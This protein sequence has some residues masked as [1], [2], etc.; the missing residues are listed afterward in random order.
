MHPI[1]VLLTPLGRAF[2]NR[3]SDESASLSLAPEL[4]TDTRLHLA[5][6]SFDDGGVIPAAHC[7]WLIGAN[8]SPALTWRALPAGT[9]ELLL[10]FEDLDSPGTTPRL[11]TV[12][13]L[14]ASGDGIA[15]GALTSQTA[16]VRFVSVRGDKPG[17]YRGPRPLPGH[18]PHHYRFHLY[19]LDTRLADTD[20]AGIE[21]LLHS[22]NGHVLASGTLAGT[23]T[24]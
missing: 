18:G 7:G 11:H 6:P 2:R 3:R 4:A 12:A 8:V 10:V 24:A 21:S 13:T 15:E 22:A 9:V 23:R 20:L 19:A 16:G 17:G 1:E 5:S 14:A